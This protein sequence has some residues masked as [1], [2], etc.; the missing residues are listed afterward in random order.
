MLLAGCSGPKP[1]GPT[2]FTHWEL[3][4]PPGLPRGPHCEPRGPQ[5]CD[6]GLDVRDLGGQPTTD[7]CHP[8]SHI[9]G[10]V[11]EEQLPRF[12]DY[13]VC[14]LI[15]GSHPAALPGGPFCSGA[16]LSGGGGV[17]PGTPG[18]E[19][20]T[21]DTSG[22][23]REVW[24]Q[25]GRRGTVTGAEGH[26]GAQEWDWDFMGT[27]STPQC[28][29][30]PPRLHARGPPLLQQ[31]APG[32]RTPAHHP[33]RPLQRLPNPPLRPSGPSKSPSPWTS[34]RPPRLRR[35]RC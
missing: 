18:Q 34:P 24:P 20:G 13:T 19:P 25:Q 2:V 1:S 8:M 12:T 21:L 3:G 10:A 35:G 16:R 9:S 11:P 7:R 23:R 30:C 33:V 5:G 32:D 27:I 6:P 14:P 15:P 31:P 4:P 22:E 28:P 17:G 29:P 26:Q